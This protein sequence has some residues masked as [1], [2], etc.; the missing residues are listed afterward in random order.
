MDSYIG[1]RPINEV[2]G[3]RTEVYA[4]AGQT[5]FSVAYAVGYVDVFL[6][7][8]KLG[9]DDFIATNGSTVTL[10]APATAND[11]VAFIAWAKGEMVP[12]ADFVL[13]AGDT[14]TGPLAI[15]SSDAI[16]LVV[17]S[18]GAEGGEIVVQHTATGKKAAFDMRADL[19]YARIHHN[20]AGTIR[21]WEFRGDGV[22]STPF[23]GPTTVA[24]DILFNIIGDYSHK[25]VFASSWSGQ[26]ASLYAQHS[27]SVWA[28]FVIAIGSSAFFTFQSDG[29][30]KAPASWQNGSDER[31]KENIEVIPHALAKLQQVRGC[32]FNRID[33]GGRG[34]AGV[35]AQD[36]QA[37][38]PQGVS[39]MDEKG[40]LAV[41]T[42]AV[43]ALL[44][45]AVK[46]LTARVA[47]LEIAR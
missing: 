2:A 32:T 43:V 29:I 26:T 28:G 31:L 15:K 36:V 27:P 12:K 23:L 30:A 17:E 16:G 47:A 18:S 10:A 14:M 37:V 44:I 35:I 13:K 41:D 34:F 1:N 3:Y 39:V 45:E 4:T 46:E 38:L 33:F 22:F 9:A 11:L 25:A 8:V 6:N 19:N 42:T 5:V 20:M 7:G 24:G 40:H 21:A